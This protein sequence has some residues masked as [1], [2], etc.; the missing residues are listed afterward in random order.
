MKK[1][2][3]SL[4]RSLFFYYITEAL[5]FPFFWLPV[6][7]IYLS[8]EKGFNPAQVM[9]LL[10]IQE[11]L[12]IFLEIPTGIVADR[13][14]RKFSVFLGTLL[15]ALPFAFLPLI[16][17][18]SLI[19]ALFSIKALGKAFISGANSSLLYD[20]LLHFNQEEN[21]KIERNKAHAYAMMVTAIAIVLG[22]IIAQT[23]MGYTLILP[24]PLMLIGA[25]AILFVDE[26]KLSKKGEDI[27]EISYF[28]HI[29]ESF[30]IIKLIKGGIFLVLVF[31][32]TDSLLV[33]LKWMYT[34]ILSSLKINLAMIGGITGLLYIVKSFSL[35]L[36]TK[37]L[38]GENTKLIIRFSL[39]IAVGFFIF[40]FF[41]TLL[42]VVLGLFII[43]FSG[44]GLYSVLE[45]EF[46]N[47]MQS[48][49]RATTSSMVNLLS[50]IGSTIMLNLFGV[51]QL[52][53]LN[54]SI[55]F[56][57]LLF[58][59]STFLALKYRKSREATLFP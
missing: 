1:Y 50:S 19:I 43:L 26:P 14:S 22:G 56:M 24:L 42:T 27:A 32:I 58:V 3:K 8:L 29:K 9:F 53:S 44:E 59:A 23:N 55:A 18:F 36:T 52:K 47:N 15:V 5:S 46:H 25:I 17:S 4:K 57:S 31:V 10:S 40:L 28:A 38:V 2:P 21:Y 20:L 12:L 35:F 16:N 51:L 30:S 45:Q 33:N 6:L 13:V 49:Y 48:K 37:F 41:Q 11:F 39:M 7:A 34:P 54:Y